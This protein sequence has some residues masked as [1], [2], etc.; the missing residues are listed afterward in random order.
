MLNIYKTNDLGIIKK[1]NKMEMNAWIDLVNPTKEEIRRVVRGTKIPGELLIKL[2]D[3]EELPRIE[4]E[5]EA[6]LIVIDVPYIADEENENKYG[7]MPLGIILN[8]DYLVTIALSSTELL[9]DVKSNKI[10]SIY[11]GKKTRFIIQLLNKVSILYIK[12][13]NS[14]NKALEEREKIIMKSTSNKDLLGL[15]NIQKSLVYFTTSL[16]ANDILLEKLAKGFVIHLYDEDIN[17][18]EDAI[19]E[20]KQGIETAN[21]YRE[22]LSGISDTYAT[23]ISN[24]LN[25]VM[26]FLAGITIV[27]TVPTIIAAFMGM[28]VSFG[29]FGENSYAFLIIFFIS[30]VVSL[31]T[32]LLLKRKDLL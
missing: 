5:G 25:E 29:K 28:N 14:I 11:T 24:N 21:I 2:L 17:L 18:L 1:V 30:V 15:L 31:V 4:N 9:N 3:T 8:N 12:Y 16:K 23:V 13:L 10:K 20:S 32:I 27:T 22:I 26:K 7:T 19:I 6:T